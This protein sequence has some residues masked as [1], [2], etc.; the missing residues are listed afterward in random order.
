MPGAV[1]RRQFWLLT[2]LVASTV[3]WAGAR[4]SAGG[5]SSDPPEQRQVPSQQDRTQSL[6]NILRQL[7]ADE[8]GALEADE[9][10]DHARPYIER[11]I[12]LAK[13]D[14][15]RPLSIKALEKAVRLYYRDRELPVRS[16]TQRTPRS[17]AED[18]FSV[19]DFGPDEDEPPI[20]GFGEDIDTSVVV[21]QSDLNMAADRL[22][23]YDRNHDGFMDRR[24]ARHGSWSG[25]D[26][27]AVDYNHDNRLSQRELAVRYAKRRIAE[28]RN[29]SSRSASRSRSESRQREEY[30]QRRARE[31]EYRQIRSDPRNREV[32]YLAGSIFLRYD[33]NRDGG[34]DS[35]EF[36]NLG[37]KFDEADADGRGRVDRGELAQWLLRTAE[38]PNQ[39]LPADLPE[40]FRQR[41][42]NSDL[43]VTMAE[44][45]EDWTAEKV[46]EF[47]KH[48]LNGDGIVTPGECVGPTSLP[49]GTHRSHKLQI[50]PAKS[51]VYSELVV[52]AG[53]PIANLDVQISITHTHDSALD[54]FLIGPYG[55]RVELF[56]SVGGSDDHFNNT[57]FDDEA[58]RRITQGKPPFT[59]SYRPEAVDKKQPSL[60]QFY[61]KPIE[62]T[63]TLMIRAQR[64]D[65]PGA[66]H[67][68][69]LITTPVDPD[70]QTEGSE[71]DGSQPDRSEP[72]RS[73]P[74]RSE[75]DRSERDR[76]ERDRSERD[77]SER[78]RSESGRPS[79]RRPRR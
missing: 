20:P 74:D 43:Q 50:I 11:W 28:Q 24:E 60:K 14:A 52:S 19:R 18:G 46:T 15:T 38:R 47:E 77:R 55:D 66:L 23:N 37:D 73:E 67:G 22:R 53:E 64:S 33:T 49:K 4:N 39:D 16:R 75:P 8:S 36:R 41:D 78:D 59:G 32:Y 42:T 76:S 44:F 57:V 25:E 29:R 45:A 6:I 13:L 69:A 68:W 54:A 61:G 35:G 51:T 12:R 21:L 9:I 1:D 62:G 7:D 79:F 3:W 17:T 30:A 58:S 70:K 63:W 26:L 27:F 31:E 40:W 72:D 5:E 65:R 10:A 2:V 71:P 56:T 34:L 48:D